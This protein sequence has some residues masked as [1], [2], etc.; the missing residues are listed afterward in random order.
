M[1]G[2]YSVKKKAILRKDFNETS[3]LALY[4][5]FWHNLRFQYCVEGA[6]CNFFY[7]TF[8]FTEK[9]E[10]FMWYSQ[11]CPSVHPVFCVRYLPIFLAMFLNHN[12]NN[13]N[14]FFFFF[15]WKLFNTSPLLSAVVPGV[16]WWQVWCCISEAWVGWGGG[17]KTSQERSKLLIK[18]QGR[19]CKCELL[20][21]PV[22]SEPGRDGA[23]LP[24][25]LLP[26]KVILLQAPH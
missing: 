19:E 18:K 25:L 6:R 1:K 5:S 20:H 15:K 11:P 4:V 2:Q 8:C 12:N 3:N 22:S 9:E 16:P 26:R 24:L 21:L 7:Y 10:K 13:S 14:F 23:A 17:E